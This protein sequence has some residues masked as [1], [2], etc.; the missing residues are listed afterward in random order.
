M[1]LARQA[2]LMADDATKS[3]DAKKALEYSQAAE[4]FANRL[5]TVEKEVDSLKALTLS[6]CTTK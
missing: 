3:N 5:I 6:S 4:S 1:K 2:V